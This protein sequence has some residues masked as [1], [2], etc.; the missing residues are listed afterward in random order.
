MTDMLIYMNTT[1]PK[2]GQR[3]TIAEKVWQ[4]VNVQSNTDNE[5]QWRVSLRDTYLLDTDDF[6]YRQKQLE[7]LK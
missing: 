7:H 2:V 6:Y 4:V 3:L 1:P 5:Y